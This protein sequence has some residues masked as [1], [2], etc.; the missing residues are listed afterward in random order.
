MI[1]NILFDL[2][3][4]IITIDPQQAIRRFEEI[5][6]KNASQHLDSYTQSGYFGDLE[7]GKISP[8]EFRQRLSLEIG[9]EVT[10]E[11]CKYAWTGYVKEVPQRN[12][13]LLRKLRTEGYRLYLVSN[14]NPFMMSW[15]ESEDFDGHGHPLRDYFDAEYKSY[16]IRQM[17]PDEMFFRYVLMKER[18][19]PEESLFVDDGPRNVMKASE[20]YLHTFCPE[21]G[22]DWTQ[23]IYK[24]LDP[25]RP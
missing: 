17:K 21:N 25:A 23:E 16:E 4:V 5:G 19:L 2:G 6:L 13:N 12:L 22:S 8:E 9:H 24:Y 7:S 3:G 20:L 1:R 18:I 15:A 14:T 10:L 11:D